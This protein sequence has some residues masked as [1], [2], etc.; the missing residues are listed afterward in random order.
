MLQQQA[1]K[2]I[3]LERPGATAIFRR[4][5]IDFCC[6]GG[7]SLA[8]AAG[9]RGLDPA[10]ITAEL[11]ALTPM[12]GEDIPEATEDLIAMIVSRFHETHRRELPELI[13]LARRVEAVHREHPGCPKGLAAFM[14]ETAGE[15]EDHM[16][17]EE[18]VLFPILTSGRGAMAGMPISRMRAEHL[19]H[20]ERLERLAQLTNAFA[21]P[22]GACTT[23]RALY[24][25][26][27]KLDGDLREHIHLENNVLF[28]KFDG[29]E[30]AG[31]CGCGGK[32]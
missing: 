11:D 10:V 5:R 28:A 14:E 4:H 20:G 18:A 15:L 32:H 2:D 19:E 16:M 17:K 22:D 12:P 21:P 1:V 13:R 9:L 27:A 23:W 8:E 29:G 24:A 3:A 31:V 30:S 25:G 26:C 7:R 6:N